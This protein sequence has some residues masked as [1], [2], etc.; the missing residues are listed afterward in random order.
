MRKV[1]NTLRIDY[2]NNGNY[3][4]EQPNTIQHDVM[5]L[6]ESLSKFLLDG[7]RPVSFDKTHPLYNIL[8]YMVS[9]EV[10]RKKAHKINLRT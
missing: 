3:T 5:P 6:K 2:L 8:A 7:G 4:H 1:G 9:W 10:S